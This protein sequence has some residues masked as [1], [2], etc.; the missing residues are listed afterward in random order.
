MVNK[1]IGKIKDTAKV[2]RIN[3]KNVEIVE[4]YYTEEEVNK[5][6]GK[7]NSAIQ[8]YRYNYNV[9]PQFIIIS[10]PLEI[11]LQRKIN[12]MN[13]RQMIMLNGNPTEIKIIF[14]V[15]CFTSPALIDLEFEV[16]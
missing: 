1:K 10:H 13:E 7:I 5:T 12:I 11:L 6:L 2:V 16:R 8:L 15:S 3:A 14:G 9:M 4:N